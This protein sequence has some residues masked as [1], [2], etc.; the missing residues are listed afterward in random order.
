MNDN[1]IKHMLGTEN[2]LDKIMIKYEKVTGKKMKL[3]E[4]SFEDFWVWIKENEPD[5]YN[6]YKKN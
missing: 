3:T 1:D 4:S 6:S 2:G 5:F